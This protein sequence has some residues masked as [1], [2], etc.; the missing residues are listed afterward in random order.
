[1]GAN[2]IKFLFLNNNYSERT[3]YMSIPLTINYHF[4]ANRA[5]DFNH[6]IS[7]GILA[8]ARGNFNDGNGFVDIKNISNPIQ[9]G[10]IGGLGYK[11]EIMSEFLVFVENS[12]MIGLTDT[13][14]EKS[15]FFFL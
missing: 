15:K 11:F 8:H 7:L 10:F 2:E 13:T 12:N 14:K 9:F 1:M 6:G 3:K 4:G 5:W